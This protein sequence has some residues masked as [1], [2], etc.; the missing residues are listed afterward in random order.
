M[1]FWAVLLN[2]C[3]KVVY[4]TFE[5]LWLV[6]WGRLIQYDFMKE[7]GSCLFHTSAIHVLH[8]LCYFMGRVL[9]SLKASPEIYCVKLMPSL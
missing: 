5:H 2:V 8:T 3:R 7:N 4:V 9:F 1:L 6:S